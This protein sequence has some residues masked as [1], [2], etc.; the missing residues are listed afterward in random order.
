M[1]LD[2]KVFNHRS[3][4]CADA[5]IVAALTWLQTKK[6]VTLMSF[7]DD[8]EKLKPVMFDQDTSFE[9]AVEIYKKEI[10][11]HP[12][13]KQRI[14]LPLKKALDDKIK[15]DVFI[16]IVD[17]VARTMGTIVKPPIDVLQAYRKGM[18]IKTT[19]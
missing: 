14:T 11:K 7:T 5:Q 3:V 6:E 15:V 9:K 19:K 1:F 16:T 4:T 17:S 2:G 8:P 13:T 12:K 10:A 18:N